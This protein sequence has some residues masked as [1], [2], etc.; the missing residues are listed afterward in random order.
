LSRERHNREWPVQSGTKK[1]NAEKSFHRG[2]VYT[3]RLPLR[4]E[5]PWWQSFDCS[6]IEQWFACR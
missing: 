4:L 5:T 2:T 1:G 6:W 3:R